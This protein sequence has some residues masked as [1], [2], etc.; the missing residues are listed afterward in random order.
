MSTRMNSLPN[1]SQAPRDEDSSDTGS[2]V[3][4]ESSTV[5]PSF[6][7]STARMAGVVASPEAYRSRQP[8]EGA[9]EGGWGHPSLSLPGGRTID[10]APAPALP[11]MAI[12]VLAVASIFLGAV[13]MVLPFIY[14]LMS[15]ATQLVLGIVGAWFAA[16]GIGF[17]FAK[18]PDN[19]GI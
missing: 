6:G 15:V 17:V 11:S 4:Q 9:G 7:S 3:N 8:D 2:R 1:D 13:L 5:T 10:V 14:P 12:N 18:R 19:Q 16:A